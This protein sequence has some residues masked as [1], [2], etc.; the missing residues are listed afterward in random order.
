MTQEKL[1]LLTETW[2]EYFLYAF[3]FFTPIGHGGASVCFGLLALCFVIRKAI[4]PGFSFLKR[5]EHLW[6]LLFFVFCGLSLINSGPYLQKS[7]K[8]LFSKWG[9]YMMVF[10]FVRETLANPLRQKRLAWVILGV[11]AIIGLDGLYQYF[12]GHDLFY[13]RKLLEMPPPFFAA[14][15]AAFKNSNDLASYL[16]LVT[17]VSLGFSVTATTQRSRRILWPLTILLSTCLLLTFSRGAWAGF[18]GGSLLLVVISRRWKAILP[19]VFL[20]AIP[21]LLNYFTAANPSLDLSLGTGKQATAIS[22]RSDLW[23]LAFQMIRENPYL[24]KGLGTFMD[25][26]GQRVFTINANYA[27]N[28]YL[29]MWAESGIFSL[30]AFLLFIGTV[31]GKG[32]RAFKQAGDPLTLGLL[33]GIFAFLIHSFFDTQLYSVAQSFL[34]WSMLGILAALSQTAPAP[35]ITVNDIQ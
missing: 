20:F 19:A 6:L 27:H 13:A 30:L 25:Y 16:G 1:F 33:G 11:A 3:I 12:T 10:L 21:V 32:L 34:L 7:L 31:M 18:L 23:N 28:C 26:C 24:G 35:S 4:H 15:T 22:G 29:Q 9:E 17:L 2:S 8:A 14:I 5:S